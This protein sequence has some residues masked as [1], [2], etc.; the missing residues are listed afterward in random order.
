MHWIIEDVIDNKELAFFFFALVLLVV[1]GAYL[2]IV[3]D[4]ER[5][6]MMIELCSKEPN[7]YECQLYLAE[8]GG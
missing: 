3:A 6:A 8:Q 2:L 1:V 5:R 7:T 4:A